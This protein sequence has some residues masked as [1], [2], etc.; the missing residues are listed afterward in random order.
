MIKLLVA[1]T[2][3][4]QEGDTAH[5]NQLNHFSY[6][7]RESNIDSS[8]A[9]ASQ[10]LDL[11]EK[12]QYNRGII[13]AKNNLGWVFYRHNNYAQSLT[14]A[15]DALIKSEPLTY[16]TGEALAYITIAA[17]HFDLEQSDDAKRYVK[18]AWAKAS[19]N[20]PHWLMAR[21]WAVLGI[22]YYGLDLL[23]SAE[24]ITEQSIEFSKKYKNPEMLILSYRNM[25]D[26]RAEQE[27]LQQALL[28]YT[29]AYEEAMTINSDYLLASLGHRLGKC[30]VTQKRMQ[31]ALPKL[32]QA[33]ELSEK[34]KYQ[35]EYY[36]TCL[37]MEDYYSAAGNFQQAFQY[38]DKARISNA[39][40]NRQMAL[41][42]GKLERQRNSHQIALLKT[43]TALKQEKIKSQRLILIS[44]AIGASALATVAFLFFRSN[45]QVKRANKRLQ[46]SESKLGEIS[47]TRAMLLA[48]L[49]HDLRTPIS[50]LRGITHLMDAGLLNVNEV[51][52]LGK[53]LDYKVGLV[54]DLLLSVLHWTQTQA[55]ELQ[56]Q[57]EVICAEDLIKDVLP[58]YQQQA[59]SK[60]IE[61]EATLLNCH[62]IEVDKNQLGIV[63]RNLLS[64]AI[65]FTPENGVI[66]VA[67][68]SDNEEVN[69][70]VKDSGIGLDQKQME[71]ILNDGDV[72]SE[73]GTNKEKGFGIGLKLSRHFILNNGGR[74][75][76]ISERKRGATF[77][78]AFPR[79]E[80][81]G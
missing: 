28:F 50:S 45:R 20:A 34:N 16:T 77:I 30:L 35:D 80:I 65:K 60:K 52:K 76:I 47:K 75:R 9:L 19:H 68:H 44:G 41:L 37:A 64:N 46:E 81:N 69:I 79:K 43:D 2:L 66:S 22:A 59:A 71:H 40:L 1:F 51:K 70:E 53:E 38:A 62:R 8:H 24:L 6:T 49:S 10:A 12:A 31:E 7:L 74:L 11:A 58:L 3:F 57:K 32:I 29:L 26:I 21:L 73:P 36:F 39:E 27:N 61:L 13:D 18:R 23:D 78:A 14:M 63:V 72:S 33:I 56:T 42:Y 54:E 5:I 17:C 48:V 15:H 4:L 67:V 25:G 55:N